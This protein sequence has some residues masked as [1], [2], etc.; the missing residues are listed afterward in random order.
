MSSNIENLKREIANLEEQIEAIPYVSRA[1]FC[2]TAALHCLLAE[3]RNQLASELLNHPAPQVLNPNSLAHGCR[4]VGVITSVYS[5]LQ[6]VVNLAES[7]PEYKTAKE[8]IEPLLARLEAKKAKLAEAEKIEAE[9]LAKKH[10]E[11][12][13]ARAAALAK[14]EVQF[15]PI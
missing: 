12:E 2:N 11:Y 8:Q 1:I 13:A 9:A 14:V 4:I 5:E 7:L 10:E 15:A 3:K 6:T